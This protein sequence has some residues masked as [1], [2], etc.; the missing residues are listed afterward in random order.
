MK[1]LDFRGA[2]LTPLLTLL[3]A[4]VA[5]VLYAGVALAAPVNE[6]EPNNSRAQAQSIDGAFT[7]DQ[8]PDIGDVTTNTS[9]TIPHTTVE[10]TGD[11]S[12]DYYSFT[13]T[14]AGARGIFDIDYALVC[15]LQSCAD[16]AGFDA[17]IVL[18]DSNGTL[19]EDSLLDWNDDV[20]HDQEVGEGGSITGFDSYLEYTFA[21]P[22]T[23]YIAVG[24]CCDLPEPPPVPAVGF[25]G[26]ATSYKLQVS[27]EGHELA[28]TG[29]KTQEECKKNGWKAFENPDGSPMFKNQGDCVSYVATHGKNEPGQTRA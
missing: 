3:A 5:G 18:Y 26:A 19:P 29:P 25:E 22:G 8:D 2:W 17:F 11:D 15:N 23:Y 16:F 28:S 1:S 14:Q 6:G 4:M 9:T 10:G 27:L 20:S 13:V 24:S 12:V 7:L 21:T